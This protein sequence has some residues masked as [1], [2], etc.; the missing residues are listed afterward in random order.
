[1]ISFYLSVIQFVVDH[2][3]M[4]S[5]VVIGAF[6]GSCRSACR[7]LN[8][9]PPMLKPIEISNSDILKIDSKPCVLGINR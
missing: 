9:T 3:K 2:I 5:L 8:I 1:M 6:T 7:N 4:A